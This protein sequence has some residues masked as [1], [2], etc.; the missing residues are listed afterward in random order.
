MH[1]FRIFAATVA[2]LLVAG[3]AVRLLNPLPTLEGRP[4]SLA[5]SGV[6]T[7]L[8]RS[9]S[10]GVVAHPGESGVYLLNDGR[11]AFAARVQLAQAAQRTIDAQY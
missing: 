8:G 5:L 6:D 11:E 7:Q 10:A 4:E 1:W 2:A 9:L 3:V